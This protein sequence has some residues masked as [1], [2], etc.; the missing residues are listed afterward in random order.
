M[1]KELRRHSITNANIVKFLIFCLL[2]LIIILWGS[3]KSGEIYYHQPIFWLL[4]IASIYYS[5][6]LIMQK[7]WPLL[8]VKGDVLYV[9]RFG[10][11]KPKA[12]PFS[13]IDNIKIIRWQNPSI[14]KKDYSNYLIVEFKNGKKYKVNLYLRTEEHCKELDEFLKDALHKVKMAKEFHNW[15]EIFRKM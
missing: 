12:F 15:K 9:A 4:L 8:A 2:G 3:K 1:D 11:W 13:N 10:Y 5:L 14:D 6:S 7:N